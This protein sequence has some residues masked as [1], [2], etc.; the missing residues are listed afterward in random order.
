METSIMASMTKDKEI[1]QPGLA[2][3]TAL[4]LTR[5]QPSQAS[6]RMDVVRC[7]YM[8][9]VPTLLILN[10]S[11]CCTLDS[12]QPSRKTSTP[13]VPWNTNLSS[14]VHEKE[15]RTAKPD[16][17]A[18]HTS[19][20]ANTVTNAR[21]MPI[22]I[23]PGASSKPPMSIA[24]AANRNAGTSGNNQVVSAAVRRQNQE[25]HQRSMRSTSASSSTQGVG[26]DS[27]LDFLS[28]GKDGPTNDSKDKGV[29]SSS[30]GADKGKGRAT[31]N[32]I[33][34][35]DG[36]DEHDSIQNSDDEGPY[37]STSLSNGARMTTT[38]GKT[39]TNMSAIPPGI[40]AKHTELFESKGRG[41]TIHAEPPQSSTNRS[42][43]S[44]S[45]KSTTTTK[46]EKPP[47]KIDAMQSKNA[48]STKKTASQ[49]SKHTVYLP[50]SR[51]I[52]QHG[53]YRAKHG[54]DFGLSVGT[55]M[56]TPC[57]IIG[58]TCTNPRTP[59]APN[60]NNVVINPSHIACII[61]PSDIIG[62]TT[63]MRI[64]V[65]PSEDLSAS[66]DPKSTFCT[67]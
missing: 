30:K 27:N 38:H 61:L 60:I 13:G 67:E 29:S 45:L 47:S 51:I 10:M 42:P 19:N 65:D 6:S 58:G 24:G 40:T 36:S 64:N 54:E 17:Q 1:D 56:S 7:L 18:S 66:T 8:F 5:L 12:S 43:D 63:H 26:I 55:T 53:D 22:N 48:A 57:F 31:K 21:G 14:S 62:A 35:S 37:V 11:V 2:P 15:N 50:L 41:N 44:F 34:L 28:I 49:S 46:R 33:D 9:T 4:I 52:T 20:V 3:R 25:N 39:A 16:Y 23:P 59:G 32:V